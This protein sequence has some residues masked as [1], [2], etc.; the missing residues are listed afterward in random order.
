MYYIVR[1][2]CYII[3]YILPISILRIL[4]LY[5]GRVSYAKFSGSAEEHLS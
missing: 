5:Q 4:Y 2:K 3:L 1:I